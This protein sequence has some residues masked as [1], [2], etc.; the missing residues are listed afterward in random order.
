[1]SREKLTGNKQQSPLPPVESGS[2]AT[3]GYPAVTRFVQSSAPS[4]GGGNGL[5]HQLQR[6]VE[7]LS[8]MSMAGTS[9]HYNSSAPAQIG[10]LAYAAGDQIHL[11]PGQEQHLPHEAWHVVQQKQGRVKPTLQAKGLAIN[12]DHALETEADVM[13]QRAA[14][15]KTAS[16]DKPLT[17]FNNPVLQPT[18]VVQRKIGFEFQAVKSIF[19]E[20]VKAQKEPLGKLEGKFHI[21][22]DGNSS[23][24]KAV[25][26]A[27]PTNKWPELELVT[28]AVDETTA[29][30]EKLVK[31]IQD[32][33][34]FLNQ[35]NDGEYL[36]AL[37]KIKWDDGI[38]KKSYYANEER[39]YGKVLLKNESQESDTEEEKAEKNKRKTE[40]QVH[41]H[42]NLK[43][44]AVPKFRIPDGKKHFHPQATVGVK[45]EKVAD[46][47]NYVTN[48]PVKNGGIIK[49]RRAVTKPSGP[50]TKNKM[51]EPEEG[52]RTASA[53]ASVREEAKTELIPRPVPKVITAPQEAANVFGW[54]AKKY[55]T[56]YKNTW[57]AALDATN[58]IH[59][60]TPKLKGLVAIFYGLA[61]NRSH[62]FKSTKKRAAID[63]SKLIKDL[64]PFMLRTGFLPFLRSISDEEFE[65]LKKIDTANWQVPIKP[66]V[67]DNKATREDYSKDTPPPTVEEIF[68]DI[69]EKYKDDSPVDKAAEINIEPGK[70]EIK[71]DADGVEKKYD[72][73]GFELKEGEYQIAESFH[74][75]KHV[76]EDLLQIEE[77]PGHGSI[78]DKESLDFYDMKD[79]NDIGL[80]DSDKETPEK[81][82]GAVIEL[83]KLG[84]EV[85]PEKLMEFALAVFDLIVLINAGEGSSSSSSSS[86]TSSSPSPSA[87]V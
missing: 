63:K 15:L 86:S 43:M 56:P 25:E 18:N 49:E 76:N 68:K 66:K 67:T 78:A 14:Q 61:K 24:E 9:V 22:A 16:G 33:E 82:K 3:K 60:L 27:P 7:E 69:L 41:F 53:D 44:N 70:V 72:E 64:M 83:R 77:V 35:V 85:P 37:R 13:G 42:E 26:G 54:G 8:G 71:V 20:N 50:E 59:G 87:A 12:D 32:I 55:H 40:S 10:A 73:H 74:E 19:L 36:A 46:L 11:G 2:K 21:E 81:R 6:G 34:S 5:P 1:M 51:S 31:I 47:I 30:R 38:V 79:V 48:A 75:K 84:S 57:R 80:S 17:L 28:V 23:D 39:K 65:K 52:A 29:G 58:E 62:E 4:T 45:F